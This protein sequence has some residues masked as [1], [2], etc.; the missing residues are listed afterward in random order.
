[1][2]FVWSIGTIIGPSIGGCFANPA[3]N[4]PSLFSQNGI[5]A[6]FPYLLPNLLCAFILLLSIIVAYFF[7]LETHPDMRPCSQIVDLDSTTAVTP[8]LPESEALLF[9]PADLSTKSYGTLD[10]LTIPKTGRKQKD[11]PWSRSS[12]P[13]RQKVFTKNVIMLV[14]ALG[15]CVST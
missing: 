1:M 12:S 7:L 13:C 3:E 2:P 4:F 10:S 11:K 9:A 14:V 5:F 6:S 8:L 15:M